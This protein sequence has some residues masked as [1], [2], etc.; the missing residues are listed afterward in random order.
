MRK[1]LRQRV[2][3][4]LSFSMAFTSIDS[5]VLVSAADVTG[6]LSEETHDHAAEETK[7]DVKEQTSLAE[8][9]MSEPEEE[10]ED[11]ETLVP[12]DDSESEGEQ[13]VGEETDEEAENSSVDTAGPDQSAGGEE[14][15]SESAETVTITRITGTSEKE[16]FISE[17]DGC[18]I[19]FNTKLSVT[20]SDGVTEN[21]EAGNDEF[22]D[23]YGNTIPFY[24]KNEDT[25]ET[26]QDTEMTP[27]SAGTWYMICEI[28]GKE[29]QTEVAYHVVNLENVEIPVLKVGTV[30]IHSGELEKQWYQFVAPETGKYYFRTS[31]SFSVFQKTE[32]GIEEAGYS[33]GSFQTTAGVTYYL[34]FQGPAKNETTG[35]W[36]NDWT[37]E[38]AQVHGE[39]TS[40]TDITPEKEVY[41]NGMDF[42]II[43]GSQITIHYPDRESKT[44]KWP[45]AETYIDETGNAISIRLKRKDDSEIYSQEGI[46]KEGDYAVSFLVDGKEIGASDYVYHLREAANAELPALSLGENKIT[47]IDSDNFHN[48]YRFTPDETGD[49][50]IDKQ[51]NMN[52][53]TSDGNFLYITNGAFHVTGG[54]TYYIGFRGPYP[55][56]GT[57]YTWTATLS[58]AAAI[59]SI[60][61]ITDIEPEKT[62]SIAGLEDLAGNTTFVIHY[63]NGE[64]ESASISD[65][66]YSDSYENTI[67][68]VPKRQGD[69]T[70]YNYWD[71]L[72]AGSYA[73]AFEVN[74]EEIAVSDYVYQVTD[75]ESAELP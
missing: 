71:T 4:F 64:T 53:Y 75:L 29:F 18:G 48:W 9:A 26:K 28:D 63:A 32:A 12:M 31:T 39:I 14:S 24:L 61:G 38:L 2:A 67:R 27:M 73:I 43:A 10:P 1:S 49:Y 74:G 21:C 5:S 7:A 50:R 17:L 11:T 8:T 35:C 66:W 70:Q 58:K 33:H 68:F 69:D 30:T 65:G 59:E 19:A 3:L 51:D 15:S 22:T 52:I 23:R 57:D 16:Q 36:G 20:Y 6:V 44:I 47:S 41:L 45:D 13:I 25:G 42:H 55:S 37:T 54:E 40:V 60:T 46:L 34:G 62:D 56:D 72:P